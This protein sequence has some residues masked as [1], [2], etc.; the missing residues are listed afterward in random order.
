M[1]KRQ[2]LKLLRDLQTSNDTEVAHARADDLLLQW[3]ADPAIAK[4]YLGIRR[5]YA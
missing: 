3:I 2:L 5:W 1:T 4:A